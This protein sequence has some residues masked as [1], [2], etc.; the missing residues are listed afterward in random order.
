V[1]RIT[2]AGLLKIELPGGDVRLCDGGSLAFGGE[3]YRSRD[4]LLGVLNGLDEISEG[5]GDEVPAFKLSFL[6]DP[7]A[8]SADLLAPNWQGARLRMWTAEVDENTGVI[9]G[10][11]ELEVDAMIDVATLKHGEKGRML[12]LDCVSSLQRLFDLNE[13]NVLSGEAHRRV[14]PG[15]LGLNNTT[16]VG[17]QFAWGASSPRTG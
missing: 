11:P 4:P 3:Q 6:P 1:Q 13:G 14:H 5:V 9:A 17:K 10:T 8:V 2:L 12:D 15:E 7:D 16:G